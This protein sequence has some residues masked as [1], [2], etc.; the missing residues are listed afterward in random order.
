[1]GLFLLQQP[2]AGGE[3]RVNGVG[4]MVVEAD[5]AATAR[6]L[7][8][9]QSVGDSTWSGST[10]TTIAAGV[11]SDYEGFRYEVAVSGAALPSATKDFVSVSYT[12]IASDTVDLIGT[13]LEVALNGAYRTAMSAGIQD[14]GGVF[15]DDTTDINDSG[16]S[17]VALFPAVPASGDAF[18]FGATQTFQRLVVSMGTV[19]VGTYTLT[20]EYWDG[21]SWESLT[22][23][24]DGTT[25][26]KTAGVKSV[27]FALPGDW[28]T[29]TVNSQGPFYYIRA[30]IDAGT[31]TTEPLATQCWTAVGDAAYTSGTNTLVCQPVFEGMG[32]RTLQ[33]KAFPLNAATNMTELVST[34]VDDGI[35]AAV[36]S[37]V[38]A[39]PTAIPG[40]FAQL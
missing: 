3:S 25:D 6:S 20:W 14:D 28:A 36:L 7:A 16:T 18:L 11:L 35:A 23:V 24:T 37:V 8:A 17:D 27:T 5:D 29:S 12:A 31:H 10:S 30:V 39:G 40:V 9:A 19:G 4:A 22:S 13:G 34:I 21:D 33:V 15:T 26:F 2:A 32:E 38:L 1:M